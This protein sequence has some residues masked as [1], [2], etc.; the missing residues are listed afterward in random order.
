M[1]N[2][3]GKKNPLD[4]QEY[5]PCDIMSFFCEPWEVPYILGF[6]DNWNVDLWRST[7]VPAITHHYRHCGP[8][9]QVSMGSASSTIAVLNLGLKFAHSRASDKSIETIVHFLQSANSIGTLK[10]DGLSRPPLRI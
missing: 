6:A 3:Q 5:R 1:T 8:N 7:C 10:Y 4:F 2:L 9:I